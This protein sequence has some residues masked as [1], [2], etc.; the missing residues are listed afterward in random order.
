MKQLSKD[1]TGLEYTKKIDDL[2]KA[3]SRERMFQDY[4]ISPFLQR[5]LADYEIVPVDIKVSGK[6]HD[7]GKYCGEYGSHDKDGKPFDS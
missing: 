2:L 4:I 7:Y 5:V 6:A 3:D 1:D